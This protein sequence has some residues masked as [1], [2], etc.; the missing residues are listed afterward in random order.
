[1]PD[2]LEHD[3]FEHEKYELVNGEEVMMSPAH[4]RH[5]VIQG[6]LSRIIGTYLR[7]KRCRFLSEFK[8]VF[9]AK[10]WFQPDILIVCDRKKIKGAYLEGAPD[11]I[12]EILSVSTQKR[13][14]GI[15]KDVYEAFGVGE[16]WIIDPW[17]KS[18][19]VYRLAAGKYVLENIYRDY[20]EEDLESMDEKDRSTVTLTLKISMY[21]DLEIDI[22]EI[23][24]DI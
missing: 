16:Y 22:R 2:V 17:A 3:V 23:F 4:F 8:V 15:K 13:D 20:A 5:A 18:V 9:D 1:M 21:D 7:G 19:T 6:N 12:V 11:F 10:N 14:L 24:E